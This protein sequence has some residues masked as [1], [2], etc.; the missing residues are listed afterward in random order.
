MNKDIEIE[1]IRKSVD[2]VDV[3]RN[4]IPLDK[5]G[6]VYFGV[7][8]FHDDMKP[9]LSV[10]KEKQIYNCFVCGACG[11]VFTF[12]QEYEEISFEEALDK[13]KNIKKEK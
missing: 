6:K 8:P 3:I 12:I 4:Y 1:E 9:S 7:C 13:I 11:N 2:I 10:S 5:H